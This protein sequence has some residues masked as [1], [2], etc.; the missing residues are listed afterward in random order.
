LSTRGRK[1]TRAKTARRTAPH[2]T[3]PRDTPNSDKVFDLRTNRNAKTIESAIG[4]CLRQGRMSPPPGVQ[5]AHLIVVLTPSEAG[6]L[7]PRLLFQAIH[8]S[9]ISCQSRLEASPRLS[10][11]ILCI[12]CRDSV[13]CTLPVS[14]LCFPQF[15]GAKCEIER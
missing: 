4:L 11:C 15:E 3:A 10:P 8:G 9:S 7:M 12:V 5:K 14:S 2:R 1:L 6:L 13:R